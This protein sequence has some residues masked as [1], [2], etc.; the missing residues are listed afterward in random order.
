[1]HVGGCRSSGPAR[2]L[3]LVAIV[4]SFIPLAGSPGAGAQDAGRPTGEGVDTLRDC[5]VEKR[6][7]TAVVLV[8]ES[9]SWRGTSTSEPTDPE[10]LRVPALQ[11][12]VDSLALL[13]TS[14]T[15]MVGIDLLVAGFGEEFRPE[16]DWVSLEE[17]DMGALRRTVEGFASRDDDVD[18]DYVV[19]MQGALEELDRRVATTSEAGAS[20]RLVILLSDGEYSLGRSD[21]RKPYAPD[22]PLRDIEDRRRAMGTGLAELCD[23]GGTADQLRSTG[24]VTIGL[25]IRL[26]AEASFELDIPPV[27]FFTALAVGS[28]GGFTCG[29]PDSG[30]LGAVS[31]SDD[32]GRLAI[33]VFC[34]VAGCTAVGDP[35]EATV[36]R[37]IDRLVVQAA[38]TEVGLRLRTVAPDGT[39]TVV[40]LDDSGPTTVPGGTVRAAAQS[41]R[42][43][44]F[45]V[46][47]DQSGDAQVGTW[48]LSG[49]GPGDTIMGVSTQSNLALRPVDS[50]TW[51]IGSA[52]E[53]DARLTIGDGLP[54]SPDELAGAPTWDVVVAPA[55]G[56]DAIAADLGGPD[57]DGNV[58]VVVDPV[59]DLDVASLVARLV[60]AGTIGDGPRPRI[61][62]VVT[63]PLRREG[64]PTLLVP[65]DG[66]RLSGVQGGD[67]PVDTARGTVEVAA[68]DVPGR[69]CVQNLEMTGSPIG[70]EG[71]ALDD[72]RC[73]D[74]AAGGTAELD[75]GVV[76]GSVRSGDYGGVVA[77]ELSSPT[78]S[79]TAVVGVP[80]SFSGWTPVC[81]RVLWAVLVGTVLGVLVVAL[82]VLWVVSR[83][84]A[85]FSPDV[86]NSVA[87][88]ARQGVTVTFHPGRPALSEP[89]A[90]EEFGRFV[91]EDDHG[92]QVPP[93]A[94]IRARPHMFTMPEAVV[95]WDE[96]QVVGSRDGILARARVGA[97]GAIPHG[98]GG[99]WAFGIRAATGDGSEESP[100]VAE[101]VLWAFLDI[102]GGGH[103]HRLR[104]LNDEIQQRLRGP[105][106]RTVAERLAS[107]Q[108]GDDGPAT[109]PTP[110]RRGDDEDL[111]L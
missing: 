51:T 105:A 7:L 86:A 103:E 70:A 108:D 6:R 65:G 71:F 92:F 14:E 58:T 31:T 24:T 26:P 94:S 42:F 52:G 23:P 68:D 34:A 20:C 29:D 57:P 17:A 55:G 96:G 28:S 46:D 33:D 100:L 79:D 90:A 84:S 44:S 60:V 53:L 82:L 32:F 74:V 75:L 56:G 85:R 97:T 111:P 110:V 3:V 48:T 2:T 64:L 12:V 81:Q 21:A 54:I 98:I 59:P 13:A 109:V 9:Q 73:V 63:I 18:T 4:V 37:S 41:D 91:A 40:G 67:D 27:D 10:V 49:D 89:F 11:S 95:S 76:V 69:A 16:G 5:L 80:V 78:T 19:A 106:V 47:L 93:G 8:D 45:V 104:R 62:Q 99:G 102:G 39:A 38:S 22:I 66:V 30:A 87:Y 72:R 61:E 101:G 83:R 77:V 1:M 15:S 50:P 107:R 36:D 35:V 25:G 88:A 43:A